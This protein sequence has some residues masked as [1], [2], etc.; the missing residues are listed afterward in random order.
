VVLYDSAGSV[1]A[2]A[3]VSPSDPQEGT[4]T[5]FDL[6]AITAVSLSDNT[7][8]YI[9]ED[10]EPDLTLFLAGAGG[11]ATNPSI[12][13]LGEISSEIPGPSLPGPLPTTNDIFGET[14]LH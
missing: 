8:Y 7:T 12:T 5:L 1:L 3:T 9:A 13:Y 6:H 10:V 2:S 11:L 4:P 14:T